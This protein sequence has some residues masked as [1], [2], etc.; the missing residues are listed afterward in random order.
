[1]KKYMILA[2]LCIPMTAF[3]APSVRVLGNKSTNATTTNTSSMPAKAVPAK[4]TTTASGSAA[5]SRIGTVRAKTNTATVSGTKSSA[6]TE[7]RFPVISPNHVYSSVTSPKPTGG[8]TTV[9]NAEVDTDAIV[10]TV[11][12][13]VENNYYDKNEVYNNNFFNE[14]VQN[15]DDPRVYAI[16]TSDPKVERGGQEAPEGWV[17]MWI[18]E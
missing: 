6:G 1:M 8:G 17:Y 16:S 5:T 10:N 14:A 12:Q 4:S 13:K 2:L 3:A 15:V 18:E 9:V 11:M 7:S